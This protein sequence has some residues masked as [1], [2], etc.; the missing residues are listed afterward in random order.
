MSLSGSLTA[1]AALALLA[2]LLLF[3][4]QGRAQNAPA[5]MGPGS[6]PFPEGTTTSMVLAIYTA[7]DADTDPLMWSLGGVD[8]GAFTLTRNAGNPA[9]QLKFK[10]VPNYELPADHGG[11]NVYD[12]TVKVADDETPVMTTELPVTVTVT[13]V[14]EAPEIKTGTTGA[15]SPRTDSP[16]RS[17]LLQGR[18]PGCVDG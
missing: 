4:Q 17:W 13:N 9:Y 18:G 10:V 15:A 3:P 5:I 2:G 1:L 16:R 12:I 8:A 11:N 14:N 6:L 7:T